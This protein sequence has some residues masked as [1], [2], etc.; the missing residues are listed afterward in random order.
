MSR[1]RGTFSPLTLEATRLLGARVRLSRRERR[2]TTQEL[3]ERIGVTRPTLLRIERGDPSV[4][5]GAAFEAATILG[6]P[7]FDE[8]TSRRRIEAGR[9]D[10]RLAVLPKTVRKPLRI[11]NDF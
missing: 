10:D 2:W 6:V 4:S 5:L 11:D 7:L 9:V 1:T 3:A 8:D